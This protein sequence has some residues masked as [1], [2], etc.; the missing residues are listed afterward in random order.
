MK[1]VLLIL[2]GLLTGCATIANYEVILQ[3]YV[4]MHK[5]D[6]YKNWGIPNQLA[7]LSNRETLL[8][9]HKQYIERYDGYM[10]VTP[11]THYSYHGDHRHR[12][13]TLQYSYEPGYT[14]QLSCST[15]FVLDSRGYVKSWKWKG[16]NCRA[17]KSRPQ[18]K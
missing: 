16:N 15:H 12:Y 17:V 1:K 14:L 11:E 3:S 4:G 2:I 10:R 13:T 9:Y 18:A 7:K 5:D 8:I 6:L